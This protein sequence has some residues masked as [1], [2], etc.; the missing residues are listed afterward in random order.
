M[1]AVA[2]SRRSPGPPAIVQ[3]SSK[4]KDLSKTRRLLEVPKLKSAKMI[5]RSKEFAGSR[6]AAAAESGKNSNS[7]L[8]RLQ[9]GINALQGFNDMPLMARAKALSGM[10]VQE[11]AAQAKASDGLGARIARNDR[12]FDAGHLGKLEPELYKKLGQ[13]FIERARS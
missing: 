13:T 5:P 9:R 1:A 11:V 2:H 6:I 4:A 12:V 7:L 8:A 3:I 10:K